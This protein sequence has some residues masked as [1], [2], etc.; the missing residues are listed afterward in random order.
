MNKLDIIISLKVD[1]VDRI[2]NLDIIM[3]FLKNNIECNIILT[4]SDTS[5]K[6]KDRY[7]CDYI[8]NQ[9]DE[10]FNRQKGLNIGVKHSNAPIIA[11][12]DADIFMNPAQLIK[13]FNLINSGE[14][15]IVYPYDGR[16]YD[17][18][19]KYHEYTSKIEEIP[20]NECTLFNSDSVGGVVF[21]KRDVF[22]NGGGANENFKG[23]GYEDNEIY[24]RYSKLAYKIARVSGPLYHLNH[25]RTETAYDNNP[26][27]NDNIK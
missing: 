7:E 1:S 26:Y 15:D 20:L 16:F 19:K 12:Y 27:I 2:N 18:P 17:V 5:P 11:H 10:F 6:L 23:L 22:I 9:V 13:A 3:E 4:E 25:I 24:T 14:Y 21:F 8:F